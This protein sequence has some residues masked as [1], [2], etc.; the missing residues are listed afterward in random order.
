[1]PS[2]PSICFASATAPNGAVYR[3]PACTKAQAIAFRNAGNGIVVCDGLTADNRKLAKE[4]EEAVVGTGNAREDP[5]HVISAGPDALPHFQPRVRPPAG[6]SVLPKPAQ[7]RQGDEILDASTLRKDQR[8]QSRRC[9]EPL[10]TV[11]C[12]GS[13]TH[14]HLR[15]VKHKLPPKMRQFCETLCLHD[16]DVLGVSLSGGDNGVGVPVAVINVRQDDKLIWLV[17]DLYDKPTI[18]TPM[19]SDAFVSAPDRTPVALR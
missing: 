9:R 13:K 15:Q 16:A 14:A 5:A 7:P 11:G 17:Y 2:P 8:G 4:I 6:H 19:S 3:G 10:R 18:T 1:M 12:G